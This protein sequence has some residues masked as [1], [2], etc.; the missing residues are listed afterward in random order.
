MLGGR[1]QKPHH[2]SAINDDNGIGTVFNDQPEE[3]LVV[4]NPRLFP[5]IHR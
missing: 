1:V 4:L 3:R 5:L 2:T